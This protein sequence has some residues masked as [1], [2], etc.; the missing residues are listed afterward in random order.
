MRV[1]G[2]LFDDLA[3]DLIVQILLLLAQLHP[4]RR[5]QHQREDES[6]RDVLRSSLCPS[7]PSFRALPV[8][9]KAWA[10][11]PLVSSAI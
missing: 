7:S 5:K 9:L 11:Q 10:L 2:D 8:W 1:V 6:I 3:V 4:E